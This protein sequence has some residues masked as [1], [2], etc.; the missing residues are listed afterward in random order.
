MAVCNSTSAERAQH[1]RYCWNAQHVD[2]AGYTNGSETFVLRPNVGKGSWVVLF[3]G[4]LV[5]GGLVRVSLFF[6]QMA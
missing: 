3:L 2:Y 1:V 5:Y 4:W 6:L